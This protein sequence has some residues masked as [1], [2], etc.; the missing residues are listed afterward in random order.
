VDICP[1]PGWESRYRLVNISRWP[2][3]EDRWYL[4][5]RCKKCRMPILFALDPNEGGRTDQPLLMGKLV[6]TCTMEKC[7]HQADYTVASVARFRKQTDKP[8]VRRAGEN[9]KKGTKHRP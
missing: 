9:A 2:K 8:E 3:A 4:G 5:V 1:V 7:R 6:L